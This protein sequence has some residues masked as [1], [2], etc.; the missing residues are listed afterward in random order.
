M[1]PLDDPR[2]KVDRYL[3]CP[4]GYDGFVNSDKDAWT[5][6]V[7]DGHAW[8]WSVRR[9][10]LAGG[11]AMNR[12]G[13]WIFE[14]RGSGHNKA[15]RWALDEALSLALQYVDSH[16]INGHTAAEASAS[17]AARIGGRP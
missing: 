3:V 12:K 9:G 5:L 11:P 4:T 13:E 6:A 10:S 8:G 2:V 14:S 1:S 15:R 17:V 7:V 16:R